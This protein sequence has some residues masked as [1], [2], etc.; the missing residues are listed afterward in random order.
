MK[1]KRRVIQATGTE[2]MGKKAREPE[3]KPAKR[4]AKKSILPAIPGIVM[5]V[6]AI[7]PVAMKAVEVTI[8]S[9]K[10]A[11]ENL[12]SSHK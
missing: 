12:G 3:R 6:I 2:D 10:I 4:T 7:I 1:R 5:A 8:D 11:R 9:I